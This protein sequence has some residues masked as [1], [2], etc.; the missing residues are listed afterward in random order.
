M[1]EE[2][3]GE[4]KSMVAVLLERELRG[5]QNHFAVCLLSNK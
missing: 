2:V 4:E 1:G 3:A 5:S